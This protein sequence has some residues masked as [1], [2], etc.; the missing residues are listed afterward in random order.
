MNA[1]NILVGIVLIVSMAANAGAAKRGLKLSASNSLE[2]PR[3]YLQKV[4]L[5]ISALI[6]VLILLGIFNIGT[7]E[8]DQY[9][10]IRLAGLFLYILF[11]YTQ[12]KSFKT[13]GENYSQEIGIFKNHNIVK[14]GFY[15]Y[16]RHPQYISQVLSDIGAG[17]ALMSYLVLPAAILIELPLFILRAKEEERLFEKHFKEKFTE[18]KKESGFMIPF[19]G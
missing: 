16:V 6:V 5:N 4:P 11:S 10:P 2:K 12:F 8:F 9:S 13:L 7:L 3:T 15:K 19:I 17:L 14:T 18:Y 1:I